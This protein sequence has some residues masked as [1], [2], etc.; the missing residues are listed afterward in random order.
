M[1]IDRKFAAE[2]AVSVAS[3][4]VFVVAAYVVSWNYATPGNATGNGTTSPALQP[5]GGLAMVGV[6]ALFVV[7]MAAAGL[8]IYRG[9]FGEE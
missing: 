4:V 6:I 5:S 2:L 1:E 9:D 7:V 8:I 3:V